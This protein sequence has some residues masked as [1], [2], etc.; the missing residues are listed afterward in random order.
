M[1]VRLL[2]VVVRVPD[3]VASSIFLLFVMIL[4]LIVIVVSSITSFK[5]IDSATGGDRVEERLV[6]SLGL[7]VL[8][9]LLDALILIIDRVAGVFR[10]GD[11]LAMNLTSFE[12]EIVTIFHEAYLLEEQVSLLSAES[13]LSEELTGSS[14][15]LIICSLDLIDVDFLFLIH[16]TEPFIHEVLL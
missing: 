15:E 3:L 14:F 4:W 16:L 9:L 5:S 11:S 7:N 12:F 6:L 1:M 8:P 2:L 13:F 10:A